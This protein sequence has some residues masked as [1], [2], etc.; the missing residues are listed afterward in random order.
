MTPPIAL[1][2]EAIEAREIEE[3]ELDLLEEKLEIE[4]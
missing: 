1:S 4:Y 2:E 3:E